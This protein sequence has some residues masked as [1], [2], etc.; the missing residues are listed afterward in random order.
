MKIKVDNNISL[1]EIK[2]TSKFKNNLKKVV[3]QNKDINKLAKIVNKLAN[4]EKLERK[5][6]DHQLT[7]DKIYNNCRECH[8]A[9]DW[10]LIYKYEDSELVLLL[11]ATGSHTELFNK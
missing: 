2:A 11:F 8:I 6:K 1:Y 3:K 9:P 7:D 10:L 5:Y 4:G